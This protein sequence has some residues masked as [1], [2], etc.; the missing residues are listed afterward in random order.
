MVAGSDSEQGGG[1]FVL[2]MLVLLEHN[3]LTN[4]ML[5]CASGRPR[6]L[7][8]NADERNSEILIGCSER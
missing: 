2:T 6:S 5:L 3:Y 7:S 4:N 1:Y 8:S